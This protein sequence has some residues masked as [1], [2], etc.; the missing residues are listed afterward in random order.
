VD[1]PEG[2]LWQPQEHEL[3]LPRGVLLEIQ[4]GLDA[5]HGKPQRMAYRDFTLWPRG[6]RSPEEA[7]RVEAYKQ[8]QRQAMWNPS[9]P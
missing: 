8:Q 2:T 4:E 9:S 1:Y 5:M 7:A 6:Q 3:A